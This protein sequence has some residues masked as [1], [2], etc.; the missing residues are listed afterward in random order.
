MC[1]PL[2]QHLHAFPGLG[3]H[4]EMSLLPHSGRAV[5]LGPSSNPG[6]LEQHNQPAEGHSGSGHI[7]SLLESLTLDFSLSSIVVHEG[8]WPGVRSCLD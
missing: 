4:C 5:P 1:L 7:V 8:Q 2:R 3:G 6:Y